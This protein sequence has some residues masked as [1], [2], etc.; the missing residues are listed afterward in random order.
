MTCSHSFVVINTPRSNENEG[1]ITSR[2]SRN[3]P[4]LLHRRVSSRGGTKTGLERAAE[5]E[6][7]Q[8][9]ASITGVYLAGRGV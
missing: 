5:I 3:E 1:S 8:N 9:V 4:A 2:C 6:P 7:N